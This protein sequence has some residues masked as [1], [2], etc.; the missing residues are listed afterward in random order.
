MTSYTSYTSGILDGR[1][2]T[3]EQ[4]AKQCVRAFGAS[5]HMK[6]ESIVVEYKKNEPTD[7]YRKYVELY[8]KN[9][10]EIETMP[11]D[12]LIKD[13][14]RQLKE[15]IERYKIAINEKIKNKKLLTGFLIQAENYIPPT[16]EHNR[17]KEFLIQQLKDTIACDGDDSYY[18][19]AVGKAENVLAN[20]KPDEL[21]KKRLESA[22]HN[23]EFYQ[24]KYD[25]DIKG[26][27]EGDEWVKKIFDS[28]NIK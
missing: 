16:E 21:R 3:F 10:A 2:T 19:K 9:L 6:G 23:L 14:Q 1:I 5:V 17:F 28:F 7:Y 4:F 13:E 11:D 27:N 8:K 26:C 20:L 22:K 24:N 15:S 12:E 18:I 25:M